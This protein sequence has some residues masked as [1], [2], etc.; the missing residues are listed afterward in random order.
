MSTH[1]TIDA[2]IRVVILGGGY[3]GVIA[4][5]R[6]LGSLT[7]DERSHVELTVI[8]PRAAFVERIRLHQLAAGSR[9]CVTIALTDMLHPEAGL[10]IG[11]AK[12][13]D[14][15]ARTVQISAASGEFDL[16]YDYLVYAVGSVAAAPIPGSREHAYLIA[17]YDDARGAAATIAAGDK[18][19]EIAVVGGGFTGV[20][21]AS[22]LAEQHPEAAVTLY[23]AGALLENMRPDAR[24]SIKKVLRR[25]GVRIIEDAPVVEIKRRMVHLGGGDLHSF[26]VCIVAAS[27]DVGELATVSGLPVDKLGRLMV[28]ETLRCVVDPLVI[29][30]GDAVVAPD[31]VARHLRMGCAAALPLG[32]HAAET[33]LASIRGTQ[34]PTLSVGYLLQCVG[35]GHKSAYIQVVRADDSPRGMHVGGRTGAAIKDLV[36]TMVVD[37]PIKE[38]RKPGAYRW[39]KGPKPGATA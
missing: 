37:S 30:A 22:E 3:A 14:H 26:D 19:A 6:F 32:A 36:C 18:H 12:Q 2:N 17:D 8:N 34:P 5:N 1:D 24:K 15:R 38:S 13:I 7:D 10:M 27:F 39:P 11:T 29:G 28:D 21:A 31:R 25:K 4:T 20:E 33:L 35:L 9:E 16:C 23:C